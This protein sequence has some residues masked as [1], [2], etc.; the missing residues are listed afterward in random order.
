MY[1]DL[2]EQFGFTRRYNSVKR[3]VGRCARNSRSSMTG[4][5]FCP[6]KRHR[7]TTAKEP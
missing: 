3:F 6:E 4:L 2:V 7:L 5:S 1:Q